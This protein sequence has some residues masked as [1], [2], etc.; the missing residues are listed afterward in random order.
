MSS[1]QNWAE[2]RVQ[3]ANQ[4]QA[5][6]EYMKEK[7]ISWSTGITPSIREDLLKVMGVGD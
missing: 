6:R 7:S 1:I 5:I 2:R 4:Y 3:N